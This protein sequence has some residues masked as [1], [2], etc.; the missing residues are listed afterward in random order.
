M[1]DTPPP[2]APQTPPPA[3]AGAPMGAAPMAPA[4]KQTLSLAS[5]IVGLASFVLSWFIGLGLIPGIVAV[6]L[7]F[8]AKKSE[9]GAPQWMAMVGIIAGFVGI[10]LSIIVGLVSIV[11]IL[12]PLLFFSSYTGGLY[13]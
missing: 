5:F 9:P 12:L 10:G 7:G 1:T 2:A 6:V 3:A 8:K 13:Y 11:T 4:P